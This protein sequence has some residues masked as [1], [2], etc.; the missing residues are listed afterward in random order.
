MKIYKVQIKL[1]DITGNLSLIKKCA[2]LVQKYSWGLDYPVKAIDEMRH[3]EYI[4]AAFDGNKL[5]G[6]ASIKRGAS[7]DKIDK[8]KLWFG[9][10]LVLSKYRKHG[11]FKKTYQKC[12]AYIRK[13]NEQIFACTDNIIMVSFLLKNGWKYY[14]TTKDESGGI[15]LVFKKS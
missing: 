9:N 8:N 6:C 3:A 12:L 4:V 7:P 5:I 11:I 15:C 1:K 10:A 14:R 13:K 2:A